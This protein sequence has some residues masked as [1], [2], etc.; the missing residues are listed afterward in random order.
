MERKRHRPNSLSEDSIGSLLRG[1]DG[2]IRRALADVGSILNFIN[3]IAIEE[4][5]IFC[6]YF[7]TG[8]VAVVLHVS[9]VLCLFDLHM[10]DIQPLPRSARLYA[11]I[12]RCRF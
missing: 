3:S 7:V 4:S 11:C 1:I 10:L 12:R 6:I 2:C 5:R 9:N 8:P